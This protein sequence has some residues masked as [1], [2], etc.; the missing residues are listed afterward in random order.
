MASSYSR[1]RAVREPLLLA[2]W[3][4]RVRSFKMAPALKGDALAF[5]AHVMFPASPGSF[6]S[7]TTSPRLSAATMS[8]EFSTA[9]APPGETG[10][11]SS[12]DYVGG[13]P[14]V[15]DSS[16]KLYPTPLSLAFSVMRLIT[17]ST[18]KHPPRLP[19]VSA[20]SA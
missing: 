1:A 15:I 18:P 5:R 14:S 9:P 19:K 2:V 10:F 3:N 6:V 11:R 20:P 8:P 17:S 4:V 16:P 13:P 12:P 7:I